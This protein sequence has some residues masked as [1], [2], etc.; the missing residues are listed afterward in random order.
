MMTREN[1]DPE[2]GLLQSAAVWYLL[3]ICFEARLGEYLLQCCEYVLV[4]A[5]RGASTRAGVE[6]VSEYVTQSRC[7]FS[8]LKPALV[9]KPHSWPREFRNALGVQVMVLRLLG[10]QLLFSSSGMD[11]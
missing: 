10:A 4:C 9:E 6:V 8:L 7:T 3:A 1:F 2:I 11:L 5:C